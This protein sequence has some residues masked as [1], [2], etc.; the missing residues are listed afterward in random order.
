[1]DVKATSEHAWLRPSLL[2]RLTDHEPERR[3]ERVQAQKVDD[4]QLRELV[5]RDLTWLF[6]T[7]QLAA[8]L[9]IS[10][11]PEISRSVLNYGIPALTGRT[12]SGLNSDTF[13]Q[14]IRDG[15]W[16]FE[17]RLLRETIDIQIT[18]DKTSAGTPVLFIEIS[19][20]LRAEPLPMA[21]RVR[22]EVDLE[23]G[24]VTIGHELPNEMED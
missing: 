14:Q 23:S 13:K 7:T 6:N 15:L 5:R 10:E 21:M 2:D 8:S 1:M 3:R 20:S 16:S 4:A 12:A 11:F 22:A 24:H 17:T 18:K 19:A 9:D